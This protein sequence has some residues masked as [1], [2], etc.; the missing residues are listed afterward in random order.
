MRNYIDEL[1]ESFVKDVV[2]AF[3]NDKDKYSVIKDGKAKKDY[4]I[5][6]ENNCWKVIIS[7]NNG[8]NTKYKMIL[9][10][11]HTTYQDLTSNTLNRVWRIALCNKFGAEYYQDLKDE[12]TMRHEQKMQRETSKLKETLNTIKQM[13][14]IKD[15]EK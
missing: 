14:D 1:D 5:T 12:L 2:Q 9:A 7:V 6:K 3:C 13:S 15:I 4:K 10:N 11:F 8:F